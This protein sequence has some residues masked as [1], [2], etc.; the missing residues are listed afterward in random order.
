LRVQLAAARRAPNA[1]PAAL[2]KLQQQVDQQNGVIGSQQSQIALLEAR[3]DGARAQID[4]STASAS[5]NK[6]Q[7]TE[8]LDK[9][10]LQEAQAKGL[11]ATIAQQDAQIAKLERQITVATAD[12]GEQRRR[13][14]ELQDQIASLT[15]S[16]SVTSAERTAFANR[17]AA[18]Q[19]TLAD[20]Q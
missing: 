12:L 16:T 4:A 2:A 11:A 14:Q 13:Q 9:V 19:S 8:A 10:R 3:L 15:A 17:I 6:R 5:V 20:S 18:L 7:L 1:D